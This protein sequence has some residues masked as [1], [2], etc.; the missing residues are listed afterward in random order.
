MMNIVHRDLM[1]LSRV[2]KITTIDMRPY[3]IKK[4]VRTSRILEP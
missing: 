3:Y 1:S 2:S 4:K